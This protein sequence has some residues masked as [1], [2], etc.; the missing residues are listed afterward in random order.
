MPFF[1][2]DITPRDR[3]VPVTSTNTSHPSDAT[4]MAG[5]L[6][7]VK[8][9]SLH[10]QLTCATAAILDNDLSRSG[11]FQLSVPH[12]VDGAKKPTIR[13]VNAAK[14]EKKEVSLS[15][16]LQSPQ[17]RPDIHHQIGDGTISI[18]FEQP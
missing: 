12:E 17:H 6:L 14:D 10:S 1:C 9:E 16:V 4:G 5:V 18:K 8:E 11:P 3:R 7:E 13:I 2:H 15:L